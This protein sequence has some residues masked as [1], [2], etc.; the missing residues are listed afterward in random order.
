MAQAALARL[1]T[2][3]RNHGYHDANRPRASLAIGDE[4]TCSLSFVHAGVVRSTNAVSS[5]KRITLA[6]AA[7]AHAEQAGPGSS[8]LQRSLFPRR[9]PS[10]SET[11]STMHTCVPSSRAGAE[12]AARSRHSTIYHIGIAMLDVRRRSMGRQRSPSSSRASRSARSIGNVLGMTWHWSV[13][14]RRWRCSRS[15][16]DPRRRDARITPRARDDPRRPQFESIG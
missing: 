10:N 4:L 11:A 16:L 3:D 2:G 6:S 1:L 12:A 14:A 5:P 13:L 9:R 15:E 7:V 8:A